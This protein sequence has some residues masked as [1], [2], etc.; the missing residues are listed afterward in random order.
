MTYVPKYPTRKRAAEPKSVIGFVWRMQMLA[1]R[2]AN[3]PDHKSRIIYRLTRSVTLLE[4]E[5]LGKVRFNEICLRLGI[6]GD[7]PAIEQHRK[8]AAKLETLFNIAEHLPDDDEA[9]S[10]VAEIDLYVLSQALMH[11]RTI[12]PRISL[13]DLRMIARYSKAYG[14]FNE[15]KR[16]A[17]SSA[18]RPPA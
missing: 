17:P 11:R 18:N 6:S 15:I 4:A 8:I 3:A 12:N 5:R 1:N 7:P 14:A 2:I 16:K 10:V 13:D 9:L